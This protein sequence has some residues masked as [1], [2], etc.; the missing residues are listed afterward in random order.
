MEQLREMINKPVENKFKS[1][2]FGF[3][4]K[5]ILDY[6]YSLEQNSKNS[7][8]NYE[9]KLSEQANALTMA[10]REKETLAEK[11]AELTKQVEYLSVDADEQKSSL[12]AENNALKNQVEELSEYKSKNEL[13][14]TEII[15]LK[16]RCEYAEKERQGLLETITE[17]DEIIEQ[18]CRKNADS[19]RLLKN[20]M[21]K[22]KTEYESIRKVQLLNIQ[23][24]KEGLAKITNIVEQL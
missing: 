11:V 14:V 17:K 21:E 18:Q 10:L 22:I 3:N 16:S 1:S 24:V 9:K 5:D 6:I 2:L 20:E 7:V 8:F 12:T 15:G 4:K 13:L 23:S 19:E